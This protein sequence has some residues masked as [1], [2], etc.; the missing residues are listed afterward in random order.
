ME[1]LQLRMEE[2]WLI[3]KKRPR[4]AG[5]GSLR[6]WPPHLSVLTIS[7]RCGAAG[8]AAG[9]GRVKEHLNN[10]SRRRWIS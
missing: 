9:A 7:R 2:L 10:L 1:D 5:L 6:T 8:L 3:M 4:P